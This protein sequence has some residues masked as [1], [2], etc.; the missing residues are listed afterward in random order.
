MNSR[1]HTRAPLLER[2][3]IG[4]FRRLSSIVAKPDQEDAIHFLNP[5]ERAA[6]R[7]VVR[8]AIVRAC[9]A[10]ALSAMVSA[11]T[12]ILARPLLGPEPDLATTTELLRFWALLGGATLLAS[13][14]EIGFLY[15]DGL[16]S[17]H[18][19]AHVAGLD[20][21]PED[22]GDE[23][24]AVAGAMA[25]AA[26]ELPNS[27]RALFGID[28]MREASRAFVVFASL[29]YKAKISASSFALKMLVRR[30][31]GR[32]LVRAWLPLIGVPVTAIW[33]GIV[34]W[35]VLREARIRAMG[36]SAAK[37]MVGIVFADS[38]VLSVNGRAAVKRAVAAAIVR[39]RDLHPNLIALW[40]EVRAHAGEDE[41][42]GIDD[43]LL[44]VE[45]L[46]GLPSDERA[47]VLRV[48]AIASILDG[49]ITSAERRLLSQ[50]Y[51]ACDR[52]APLD[53]VAQL[54]RAFLDGDTIPPRLIRELA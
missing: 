53:R 48:L 51:A 9:V 18:R 19:L 6:L 40:S 10:G 39:T 49:R 21:F 8:G 14:I 7:A 2:V 30:V 15:W 4:Y 24:A 23:H 16:R 29:A 43:A 26:L 34:A 22:N 5:R 41:T 11:A 33:N 47:I 28:P 44:F 46:R 20:L 42:H 17:V 31:L 54:R 52:A 3:G 35:L 1:A 25:R 37:E 45:T 27:T 50:S 32:A 36:P 12:E 38:P 13:I